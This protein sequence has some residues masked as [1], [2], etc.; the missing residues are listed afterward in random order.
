MAPAT[1]ANG[2]AAA[3]LLGAPSISL[4]QPV[5]QKRQVVGV[6]CSLRYREEF[7]GGQPVIIGCVPMGGGLWCPRPVPLSQQ[8]APV[9][10]GEE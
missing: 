1:P 7:L 6:P 10:L 5:I 2:T 4:G 8:Q 3:E 9:P